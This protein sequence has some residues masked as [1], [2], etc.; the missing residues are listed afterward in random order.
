MSTAPTWA[1]LG[2]EEMRRGLVLMRQS[3]PYFAWQRSDGRYRPCWRIEEL[4]QFESGIFDG[5]HTPGFYSIRR[6]DLTRWGAIDF[7]AHSPVI[8][9]NWRDNAQHAFDLLAPQFVER[10]LV[11]SSPGGFH[12]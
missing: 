8:S 12:V 6:D 2:V 1:E 5:M 10:W 11:E 9:D 4:T 7:D 3:C